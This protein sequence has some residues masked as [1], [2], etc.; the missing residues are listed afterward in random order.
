MLAN[1]RLL[2]LALAFVILA[3]SAVFDAPRAWAIVSIRKDPLCIVRGELATQSNPTALKAYDA[4]T[5]RNVDELFDLEAAGKYDAIT[6]SIIYRS[7]TFGSAGQSASPQGELGGGAVS[8]SAGGSDAMGNGLLNK[9]V[10][11]IALMGWKH[12]TWTDLG[13]I[14]L[15]LQTLLA[16]DKSYIFMHE[17]EINSAH[18]KAI[19]ERLIFSNGQWSSEWWVYVEPFIFQEMGQSDEVKIAKARA[20][21]R[22]DLTTNGFTLADNKF[23]SDR[24]FQVLPEMINLQDINSWGWHMLGPISADNL[25]KLGSESLS[26]VRNVLGEESTACEP[27]Q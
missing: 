12:E 15:Q 8:S 17:R 18:I 26:L 2:P 19:G 16:A 22:Y 10:V 1:H 3:G 24:D 4:M 13:T 23:N 11:R 6:L 27:V 5:T 9:D 20:L 25:K 21:Q 7:T 14:P